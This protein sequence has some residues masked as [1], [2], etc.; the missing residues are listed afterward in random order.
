[1]K[2]SIRASGLVL[3]ALVMSCATWLTPTDVRAQ[4]DLLTDD[5]V[6][7]GTMNIDFNTRTNLD[8]SGD[9]KEGSA[10]LGAQDKYMVNLNVAKTTEYT[11]DILRQPKLSSSVLGRTKQN[12][13]LI[14]SLSV[15]VLNPHD[16]K[17]KKTVGKW[18]GEMAVDPN[19][20]AYQLAQGR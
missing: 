6:I 8:S 7:T 2:T 15:A 4:A 12:A 16:L 19:S 17:Q 14:Y 5:D 13:K 18:V 3:L 10:A 20:G 9:L 1:M 11:G